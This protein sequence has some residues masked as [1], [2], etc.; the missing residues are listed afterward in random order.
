MHAHTRTHTYN[1]HHP[2]T[3]PKR[4]ERPGPG[5]SSIRRVRS[6]E[7]RFL[8]TTFSAKYGQACTRDSLGLREGTGRITRRDAV[9]YIPRENAHGNTAWR[10]IGGRK[11]RMVGHVERLIGKRW[12]VTHNDVVITYRI[13]HISEFSLSLAKLRIEGKKK[14]RKI[15]DN[16]SQMGK[17]RRRGEG[18]KVFQEKERD[19]WLIRCD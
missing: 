9:I 13:S 11:G 16:S 5:D 1:T 10:E 7:H 3:H 18:L 2:C 4:V 12:Y 8:S 15:D 6:P 17:E 19:L 14:K